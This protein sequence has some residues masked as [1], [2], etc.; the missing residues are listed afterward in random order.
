MNVL[1]VMIIKLELEFKRRLYKGKI[2]P[3]QKERCLK[4]GKARYVPLKKLEFIPRPSYSKMGNTKEFVDRHNNVW[5][6][7]ESRTADEHFEWDV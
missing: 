5:V 3:L 2:A 1:L 7:G 4:K 6:K